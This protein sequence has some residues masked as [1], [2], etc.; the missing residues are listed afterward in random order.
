MVWLGASVRSGTARV[1][2]TATGR[3]TAFGAIAAR[4]AAREPETEFTRGVRR[5]GYLLMRVMVLVVLFVLS[6]NL[7]LDRP[8][9]DSL[10]FAA[11][12]AVGLSPELLPAIVSVTL[13]AGA[14]RMAADGVIV[15]RLEAIENLGSMTVLCTDKTGTLT[16]GRVV[17]HAAL[18]SAGASS[19]DVKRLAWL[20]ARFETGSRTP[21]MR[22]WWPRARKQVSPQQAASRSTRSP[23]TSNVGG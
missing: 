15:R 21:S 23:M 3:K 4:I 5:F 12:L 6:A 19:D 9:I 1:L 16:E 13:S 11:A 20:N 18:D 7:M 10:L 22:H 2:V 17:L 14:R 8:I